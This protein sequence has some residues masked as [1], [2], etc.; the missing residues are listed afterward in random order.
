M[1]PLITIFLKFG[2]RTSAI[3]GAG[4]LVNAI[5]YFPYSINLYAEKI[6][7]SVDELPTGEEELSCVY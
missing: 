2:S 6:A 3:A 1:S 4:I 5:I 7:F